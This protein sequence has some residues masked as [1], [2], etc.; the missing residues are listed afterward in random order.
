MST[1][2]L[3]IDLDALVANWR[4]LDAKSA[5]ETGA[6]VKAGGYGLGAPIVARR[7]AKAGARQFFVAVA[8]EGS[9]VRMALGPGPTINVMSGHMSGDTE[10][11][12]EHALTPMI[13]SVDQMLR[14]VEALPTCPFGV[15]LDTGMNRLGMEPVEWSALRDIALAQTPTLI[16]SHLACSDT[17]FDP[18]NAQQLSS[19]RAMTDGLDVPRS[20]AAT[21]GIL[22][23]P[24]YHFDL[25]RPGVGLYGGRPFKDA[26]S[27]VYQADMPTD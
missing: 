21:G 19:F 9:A 2:A 25:T 6:V 20:L 7:L 14:H 10:M 23:G 13:N 1:A 15:Q 5:T 26:A 18:M 4:A 3:S 11:L 8:E 16:M 24:D 17:P 22:L 12:R 27:V